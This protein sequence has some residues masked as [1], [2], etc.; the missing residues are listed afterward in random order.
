MDLGVVRLIN[1][2]TAASIAHDLDRADEE[3]QILVY[4]LGGGT[5]DVTLLSVDQGV[6]EV[7]AVASDPQLSGEVLDRR[8]VDKYVQSTRVCGEV[9]NFIVQISK[10]LRQSEQR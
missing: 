8:V 7:L 2:S 3:S 5:L 10:R 4:D 9:A 6:F 1:E